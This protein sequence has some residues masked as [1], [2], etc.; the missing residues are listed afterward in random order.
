MKQKTI[1]LLISAILL[2]PPLLSVPTVSAEVQRSTS[3]KSESVSGSISMGSVDTWYSQ[4]E[5]LLTNT[6]GQSLDFNGAEIWLVADKNISIENVW[7]STGF[8]VRRQQGNT[9]IFKHDSTS[10]P[11]L[12]GNSIKLILGV[13]AADGNSVDANDLHVEKVIVK[14]DPAMQ[15]KIEI[16]AP[17]SP[18]SSLSSASVQVEGQSYSETVSVPWGSTFTLDHLSDGEYQLTTLDV[19][20]E[21]GLANA[22]SPVMSVTVNSEQSPASSQLQYNAFIY[23]AGINLTLP[24]LDSIAGRVRS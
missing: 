13:D 2:S 20:S 16:V 24:A 22:V 8:S 7:G 9:F 11:V 1:S 18:H 6:S 21:F 12:S 4:G 3:V 10:L 17:T 15:G 5:I 23:Y 19:S 14:N